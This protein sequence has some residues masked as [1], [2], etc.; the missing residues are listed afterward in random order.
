MHLGSRL[1]SA[2]ERARSTFSSWGA[3]WCATVVGLFAC[4]EAPVA[5][6][7]NEKVKGRAT[8]CYRSKTDHMAAILRGVLLFLSSLETELRE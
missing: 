7:L 3:N 6:V 2:S 5:G 8:R 1:F 4:T